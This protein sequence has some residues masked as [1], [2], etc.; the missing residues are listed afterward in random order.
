MKSNKQYNEELIE[1][2]KLYSNLKDGTPNTIIKKIIGLSYPI[3]IF[4]L[5]VITS[6]LIFFKRKSINWINFTILVIIGSVMGWIWGSCLEKWDPSYPGWLFPL[7]AIIGPEWIL[8][9]E[10]WIFYPVC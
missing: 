7:W 3:T 5:T 8:T 1:S 10:D 9:L 2:G 6:L 4:F